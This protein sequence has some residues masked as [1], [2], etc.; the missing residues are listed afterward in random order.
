MDETRPVGEYDIGEWVRFLDR[1]WE[2][3]AGYE[4]FDG[5]PVVLLTGDH[6]KQREVHASLRMRRA[7]R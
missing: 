3:T 7:E 5:Y 2:V 6:G 4:R 1:D